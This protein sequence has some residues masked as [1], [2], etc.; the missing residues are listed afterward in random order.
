MR[1]QPIQKLAALVPA[2]VVGLLLVAPSVRADW[3]KPT[4]P[5]I[6]RQ[7]IDKAFPKAKIKDV[8]REDENG[9]A[10]YSLEIKWQHRELDVE[11]A[12]D[13]ALGEV[14]ERIEREA[15]PAAVLLKMDELVGKGKLRGI[16]RHERHGVAQDGTFKPLPAVQVVYEAKVSNGHSRAEYRID[17]SGKLLPAEKEDDGDQDGEHEGEQDDD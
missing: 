7:A 17:P 11:V 16:E 1:T 3:G 10:F 12:A 14:E 15:V 9:V 4:V 5:A 8:E 2:L 6:V 13:G